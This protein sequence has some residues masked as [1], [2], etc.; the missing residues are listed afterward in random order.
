MSIKRPL[1][2]GAALCLGLFLISLD[3]HGDQNTKPSATSGTKVE[4]QSEAKSVDSSGEP[5]ATAKAVAVNPVFEFEPV[6]EGETVAH[7]F[8]I[9]NTGT[10]E[11][12]ILKVRTG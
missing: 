5:K 8:I 4:T 3:C 6:L 10:A 2:L 7:Q 9:K 11:L 12:K 1:F